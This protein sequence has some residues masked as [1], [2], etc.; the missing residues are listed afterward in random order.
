MFFL[1]RSS[2]LPE[3]VWL[4]HCGGSS[5]AREAEWGAQGFR[6]LSLELFRWTAD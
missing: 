6:H 5:H 2:V 3:V 4:T 1:G